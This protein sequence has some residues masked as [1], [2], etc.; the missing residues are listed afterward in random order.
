MA[1]SKQIL[2]AGGIPQSWDAELVRCIGCGCTEFNACRHEPRTPDGSCFWVAVDEENRVGLCSC[3]AV[4]PV[5]VLAERMEND[6]AARILSAI[7]GVSR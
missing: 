6:E 3:C 2:T 5:D 1:T 4:I 7:S